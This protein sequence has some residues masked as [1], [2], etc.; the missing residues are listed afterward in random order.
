MQCRY[1][2]IFLLENKIRYMTFLKNSTLLSFLK[3]FQKYVKYFVLRF[4]NFF[5]SSCFC[6]IMKLQVLRFTCRILCP[7]SCCGSWS[8][9]F[10]RYRFSQSFCSK[11]F[12][13]FIVLPV[14]FLWYLSFFFINTGYLCYLK[15]SPQHKN[16]RTLAGN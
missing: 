11:I 3:Q 10:S 2:L 14:L 12:L 4:E 8:K 9:I 1:S 13:I 16:I 5:W 6:F 7:A 15:Q